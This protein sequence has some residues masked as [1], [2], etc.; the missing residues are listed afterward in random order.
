M[1]QLY[2][3]DGGEILI[4]S[5]GTHP[6]VTTLASG[7]FV[8]TWE[9]SNDGG[10]KGIR[11]QV[12]DAAGGEVGAEFGVNT[13]VPGDQTAPA[14][15]AL[16]T[17][18][19]VVTWVDT[20]GYY[21]IKGQIFDALGTKVGAEFQVN[22]ADGAQ[23]D[24]AMTSLT[25]GGF[26]VTWVDIFSDDIRVQMYDAQG[27]K[28]G[29]ELVANARNSFDSL[30]APTITSLAS[31]GFVVSWTDEK[32]DADSGG[33]KAQIFDSAGAK[34]GSEFL[35]NSWTA[36]SQ[37]QPTITGLAGGGFVVSWADLGGQGGDESFDMA[38]K[39]QVF[40]AAGARV[41]S[42]FLVNTVTAGDQ[43]QPTITALGS[44]GFVVCWKDE[45]GQGGDTSW[46]VKAQFFDAS[47][48]KVG[49]E[50]LVNTVTQS[51]QME[52]T[53]SAFGSGGFV[54]SWT[55]YSGVHIKAQI[56]RPAAAGP[57]VGT[58]GD[59][60]LTGTDGAETI[61]GLAGNDHLSGL[62]GN[63]LLD[64]G[65][66][67]D[68][69]TGGL[70]DDT[71]YVDNVG[72]KAFEA[73]VTGTDTV[74]SSVGYSLAGQY[75]ENLVLTG[76]AAIN[77][78]G[79]SLANTI[80]GN[81]AANQING[82]EGADA[83][84]GGG[85]DDTYIVDN[86]GDKAFEVSGAGTDTV[87]ASVNYSLAGQF[88]E[89]LVLTGA[90]AINGTGNSLANTITGNSAA[91]QINGG[92]GAD[93]MTG[94]GGDDTYIVDNAG[95]KAFEVSGAG[96]DTVRSSVSYSLA[97]QFIEKL[98]LTGAAAVNG[99][100]NSLA[101]TM[102]GNAAA[103]TLSGG[104]GA[105]QLFG[106]GGSD[107]LNGGIGADAFYFDSALGAGNV[108][109]IQAYS[110]ADDTIMLDRTIFTGIGANGSLAA[111]AFVNG[112]EA[113]DADDRIIYDSA[114]GKIFYDADGTGA[115][116]AVLF[117]QLTAGTALTSLDFSAYM[118]G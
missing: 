117:A 52:P 105:D 54:V 49:D 31:G 27:A 6:A 96:T 92:E 47:G 69:M 5:Y 33:I 58:E 46:S 51:T 55:D 114:S 115:G 25:T 104:E 88:I 90:S 21:E 38:V 64:G 78:T 106:R 37:V 109:T 34:V 36:N 44:G 61:Q 11:A 59:D 113:A 1:T 108:D 35:V 81:A 62:G 28:V 110:V 71:Y 15:T 9:V 41:G 68:Q 20:D 8:V 26:V 57:I 19:F 42:E 76:A 98:V 3:R 32:G 63:D 43:E 77:G 65:A 116:A 118:P 70:G 60:T 14:I 79:N 82:G 17:G 2:E 89:N 40:D 48:A 12:F 4:T 73:N 101:N 93:A 30:L 53:I 97:G 99:T 29:S 67:G 16:D 86:G 80:T 95:D 45:S 75:I 107:I 91:N 56:F 85:G 18:G 50:F 66:G 74:R 24:P 94:G 23:F 100:G 13:R 84:T 72:D 22:T 111:S 39:G 83:M 7:G 10:G 103:N 87:R 112:L 102:T